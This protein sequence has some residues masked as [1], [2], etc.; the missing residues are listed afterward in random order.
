MSQE[1]TGESPDPGAGPV[2]D[3]AGITDE[4]ERQAAEHSGSEAPG[5]A[6]AELEALR[7]EAEENRDKYLR[8]AAELE[9]LRKRA[10]RDVQRAQRYGLERLAQALL[11]VKDSLEAGLAAADHADADALR[12]GKRATLR[13]LDSALDQAGIEELDPEGEPFD[14]AKHEAMTIQVSATAEPNT[15]VTVVQ[16]GYALHDR[17]LRPARVIV[18]QA[19]EKDG[20]E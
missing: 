19:P 12:E 1:A 18:A 20:R 7:R 11:P 16:K 17:L 9:N 3:R 13:L 5:D 15:V 14:P 2:T 6:S 4:E 10:E 8:V